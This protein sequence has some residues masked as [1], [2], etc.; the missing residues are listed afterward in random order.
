[1][2]STQEVTKRAGRPK[3]AAKREAVLNTA[4]ALFLS[5]GLQNTSMDKVAAE[6]GVSKQTVYSHFECKEELFQ[7]CIRSK[8]AS[9]RLGE[10]ISVDGA[11]LRAILTE[12][13]GRFI[14]LLHDEEV[15]GMFRV[16]ISESMAHPHIARLFFEAGPVRT[17]RALAETLQAFIERG[18]LSLDD[19]TRGAAEYFHLLKGYFD[20]ERMLGLLPPLSEQERHFGLPFRIADHAGTAKKLECLARSFFTEAALLPGGSRQVWMRTEQGDRV[21]FDHAGFNAARYRQRLV[22]TAKHIG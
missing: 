16:V 3:S 7:A 21:D 20:L 17:I 2:N 1:M 15:Q 11:D 12:I 10:L 14:E 9:H 18:E 6:A 22:A 4:G 8:V 5:Q 19:S 13:G